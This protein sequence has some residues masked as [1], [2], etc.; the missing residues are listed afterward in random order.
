MRMFGKDKIKKSAWV[1]FTICGGWSGLMSG[2]LTVPF[3]VAAFHYQ[4]HDRRFYVFLAFF[5]LA[6]FAVRVVWKN[7]ELLDKNEKASEIAAKKQKIVSELTRL[8]EKLLF[9][10]RLIELDMPF[11]QTQFES[12]LDVEMADIFDGIKKTLTEHFGPA[13][14]NLFI[15]ESGFSKATI[16]S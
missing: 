4:G 3:T 12:R 11:Y 15:D 16:L 1:I 8:H 7:Y 6:T 9:K 5:A 10:R 2:G 13:K 14:Y